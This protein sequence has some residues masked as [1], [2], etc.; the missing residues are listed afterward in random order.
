MHPCSR[1]KIDELSKRLG[2][3]T[4]QNFRIEARECTKNLKRFA[5]DSLLEA[6]LKAEP[7]RS[8]GKFTRNLTRRSSRI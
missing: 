8:L 4:G 6:S 2:K 7:E 3:E 1:Y 5:K